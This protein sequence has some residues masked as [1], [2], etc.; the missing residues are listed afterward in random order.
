MPGILTDPRTTPRK[1]LHLVQAMRPRPIPV[2]EAMAV[3]LA[4]VA[5]A[6][7]PVQERPGTTAANLILTDLTLLAAMAHPP[8]APA[9][10]LAPMTPT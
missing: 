8:L 6:L 4:L 5:T 10:M 1:T 7:A 2:L 3:A 9:P